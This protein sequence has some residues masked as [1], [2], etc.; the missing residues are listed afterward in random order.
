[1]PMKAPAKMTFALA[2]GMGGWRIAG[3]TYSPPRAAPAQ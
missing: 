3:W 2:K 1:M